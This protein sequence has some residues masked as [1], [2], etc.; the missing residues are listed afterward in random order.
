MRKINWRDWL[1]VAVVSFGSFTAL[2][3]STNVEIA[4]PYIM[5]ALGM[6]LK[7]VQWTVSI[8][9]IVMT[10]AMFTTADATRR[11]GLRFCFLLSAFIMLFGS[12]ICA[13]A[14]SSSILI[15]GRAVQGFAVGFQMPLGAILVSKIFP[16]ERIG[17]AMGIYG[18]VMLLAP[19][20]GP[21]MGGYLVEKFQW[22]AIFYLQIPL[23]MFSALTGYLFLKQE[24]VA[25]IA[26][27]K[28]KTYDLMGL[29]LV[30]VHIVSM[31]MCLSEVQEQGLFRVESFSL[32]LLCVAALVLFL[33][34]ELRHPFPLLNLKLFSK[35][36][37]CISLL[38]ILLIGFGLFSSVLIVPYYFQN[39][40]QMPAADVGES[41]IWTGLI[42]SL[43]SPVCG[44]LSDM[45]F[46][47]ALVVSGLILFFLSCY[48]ISEIQL[49]STIQS[50]ILLLILGRIGFS[51]LL[52]AIYT[53]S[54]R[55]LNETEVADGAVLINLARQLGGTFGVIYVSGYYEHTSYQVSAYLKMLFSTEHLQNTLTGPLSQQ[56]LLIELAQ[57]SDPIN[58]LSGFI[59]FVEIF[60]LTAL[61]ALATIA[62]IVVHR[63]YKLITTKSA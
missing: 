23:A 36:E 8:F 58:K 33:G 14:E 53:N 9:M 54:M 6:E 38:V 3:S 12:G 30:S 44:K 21:V 47:F 57:Y 56:Q 31:F 5:G 25:Q 39:V 62:I 16:T 7:M 17:F 45:D 32:A 4:F 61:M 60:R 49:G 22:G 2:L 29:L 40:L 26:S 18:A 27:A 1:S 55:M 52:P 37:F 10:I 63:L 51:I 59:A 42:M 43:L 28:V 35:I 24:K 19:A 15:I 11:Y 41:L 50:I 13:L 46:L 20:M 48:W 34:Q